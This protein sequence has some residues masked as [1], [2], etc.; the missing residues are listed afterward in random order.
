MV[1]G[2][3]IA[4][5]GTLGVV[6]GG[7][8][9]DRWQHQGRA[10][11][12]LRVAWLCAL[13]WLPGGIL[14]PLAPTGAWAAVWLIPTIFFGSM[15]YGVAPAAIQRMMPN[16]MRALATAIYLFVIN[17]VGMASGPTIAALLTERVFRNENSL[18]HSLLIVGS[19]SFVA[20]SVLLG[21]SLKRYRRSLEYL[22][23][24]TESQARQGDGA[25]AGGGM[26]R[27]QA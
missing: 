21:I 27:E 9:A 20:A 2:T 14:F 18:H 16:T 1:F 12:P 22:Q 3:M 4:V 5:A 7:W 10:D 13:C 25:G 23:T 15:P 17:L 19:A 11:A 26:P 24:W 6:A 8:L